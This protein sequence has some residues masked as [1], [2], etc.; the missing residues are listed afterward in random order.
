[1]MAALALAA[2]VWIGFRVYTGV[3]LEDALIT[4]RHAENLAL[5]RGFGFNPGEPVFGTTSP[6]LTLALAL[7]AKLFGVANIPMIS[8]VLAIAAALGTGAILARLLVRTGASNRFATGV[9]LLVSLQ[10]DIVWSTVGGLETPIVIFLMALG[11]DAAMRERWN[12][13]AVASGLLVLTRV[14]GAVWTLLLLAVA[15]LRLRAKVWRP[16]AA[17]LVVI[18]PWLVYAWH[19]FGSVVPHSMVAKQVIGLGPGSVKYLPWMMNSLGVTFIGD[20]TPFEFPIWLLFVVAGAA[21]ILVTRAQRAWAPVVL[22]PVVF[23]VALWLGRAPAFEWY[24][25]PLTWCCLVVAAFGSLEFRGML[26]AYSERRGWPAA[27]ARTGFTV[28]WVIVAIGLGARLVD[29]FEEHRIDQ[30]NEDG[31][32]RRVGEWLRDHSTPGATVAMEAIGYEGTYSRR[33]VVDLA[34]IVSP[35]VVRLH[36]ES[37]S[38]AQTL[39]RVLDTFRPDFLVLRS[40]EFELNRHHHG[41]PLFETAAAREQFIA[42]YRNVL[43]VTA[44]YPEAWGDNA[45]ISVFMRVGSPFVIAPDSVRA[46]TRTAAP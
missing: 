21:A 38:N 28:A 15:T 36:R 7:F 9:L 39:E 2:G 1:M 17:G 3:V 4:Y 23:G 30:E 29:A 12:R 16:L 24:T 19:T 22:F 34:G 37:R 6:L 13:V 25:V 32:R 44:P 18:A 43:S 40:Y 10:P 41:G 42:H 35:E 33:R 27:V 45:R 20:L 46:G 5:G 14:D 8:N 31:T 11:L 26:A